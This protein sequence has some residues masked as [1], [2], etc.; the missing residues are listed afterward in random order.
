MQN[1]RNIKGLMFLMILGF[2]S[3]NLEDDILSDP[4]DDRD[5][6]VSTWSVSETCFKANYTVKITIDPSNSAQVLLANFG[7]PGPNYG[8]AVGIVA[9]NKIYVSTQNTGDGWTVN[10]TGTLQ[11]THT[12]NWSYSL[13]IAGNN[14]TCTSEYIR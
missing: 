9:G 8:P 13:I 11:D 7:N 4:G 2:L 10:G 14:Y 5:K 6:F 12:I 1:L 3:C